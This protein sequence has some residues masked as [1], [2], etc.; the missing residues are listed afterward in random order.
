M[1]VEV[2]GPQRLENGLVVPGKFTVSTRAQRLRTKLKEKIMFIKE[3]CKHMEMKT[4]ISNLT[5]KKLFSYTYS[6]ATA[7]GA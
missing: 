7:V 1:M 2:T 4:T 3:L 6:D 5:E